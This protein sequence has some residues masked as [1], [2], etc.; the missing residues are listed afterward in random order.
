M[1]T[2]DF[3]PL[4]PWPAIALV[5]VVAAALLGVAATRRARGVVFRAL[6]L[7][8][9]ALAALNPRLV[10]ER[11]EARPDIAL[12]V[13]DRSGSQVSTGRIA[14]SEDALT[15]LKAQAQRFSDLEVREI[16]VTD[17]SDAAAKGGDGGTQLVTVLQ[18][19]I[20][21]VPAGRFAGAVVITD[22]QVHD[23]PTEDAVN[24]PPGPIHALL[25][26]RQGERDR[27]LAIERAPGFGIVGKHV[28][29]QYRVEDRDV[30]ADSSGARP[31]A[32]VFF[33]HD[34]RE[35]ATAVVP[36]SVLQQYSLQLDHAG[37]TLVEIEVEPADGELSPANNR[38]LIAINGVRDRL[39]VLLVSGQPHAGERTWRNLLKS[40]PSV[41]LVHFTIL[42][43]PEKDDF[44]PLVELALIAFPVQ[45]LF[46]IKLKEFDLIVFDRYVVRD[47][48][49][50][51]YMRNIDA[52]VRAG[53]ALM[54]SVGP[55]F[56]GVRSLYRT[57]LGAIMPAVPTGQVLEQSFKPTVTEAGR[58]HPLTAELPGAGL[59]GKPPEWG[60]WFRTVEATPRSGH[61][62]LEGPEGRPILVADR[63]D[64]GR[65]GL[66]LSDHIWL[67]GRGYEGGGPQA[68]F[69]R[70]LAHWLMK[71]PDLEEEGL[72]AQTR[73]R[74]LIVE[75][76][77]LVA[78]GAQINITAPSGKTSTVKLEPAPGA[79]GTRAEGDK[80]IGRAIVRV[81]ID[82]AGL[83][84]IDDGDL[85]ALAAAGA[86]NPLELSDLRA[87]PERLKPLVEATRGGILWLADGVPDL[88]QVKPG[89][90][91]AGKGWLGLRRNDAFVVAGVAQVPLLPALL[92]LALVL[93]GLGGAWWREGR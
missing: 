49:P 91:A 42:R 29:I 39:R 12:F 82:E 61:V 43:P 31:T 58:R 46:E 89:R 75:R 62:L 25:A 66:L 57:P 67:W 56:A 74:Q 30:A 72:F 76:R 1:T 14:Q 21:D 32:R 47:V 4:L 37:P 7:G 11:R 68:E 52:Y 53:G 15:K 40:D 85:R 22:G 9:L 38:A 64:K 92:V 65:V 5:A 69:L 8:V 3:A 48:L 77:S 59:P 26:G 86:L 84:Q 24:A 80:I 88:R 19:A 16:T 36:V 35:V 33:R 10:N 23:A 45:E 28:S 44:T 73:G 2:I 51:S 6:A 54:L 70:R 87:T 78:K 93:G 20:A 60:R 41:D 71:E 83:Y 55:E 34:G 18:R 81:P 13:L 27:R 79:G 90:D 50:P 63:V 17:E